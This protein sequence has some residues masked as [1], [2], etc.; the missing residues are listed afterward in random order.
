MV[1]PTL[2]AEPPF[3]FAGRVIWLEA[4][5]LARR[6]GLDFDRVLR[7]MRRTATDALG[8]P[9]APPAPG[10]DNLLDGLRFHPSLDEALAYLP[11]E[12]ALSVFER[13]DSGALS[14]R[15]RLFDYLADPT[16]PAYT[17][18]ELADLLDALGRHLERNRDP[19]LRTGYPQTS[20]APSPWLE[21]HL[22]LLSPTKLPV[23]AF[24]PPVDPSAPAYPSAS[25]LPPHRV[26][27]LY[28]EGSLPTDGDGNLVYRHV[29]SRTARPPAWS[30]D[31]PWVVRSLAD[32]APVEVCPYGEAAFIHGLPPDVAAHL[33]EG[34]AGLFRVKRDIVE[35]CVRCLRA[36]AAGALWPAVLRILTDALLWPEAQRYLEVEDLYW[37]SGV[38]DFVVP[39]Y[40]MR[41]PDEVPGTLSALLSLVGHVEKELLVG[42]FDRTIAGIAEVLPETD[43][44]GLES[45]FQ[46]VGQPGQAALDAALDGFW[47]LEEREQ[48]FWE[49][50]RSRVDAALE[51]E[52]REEVV[53]RARVKRR[54][55]ARFE[56]QIRTFAEWQRAHLEATGS[57]PVLHLAQLTTQ[58]TVDQAIFRKTGT[59]WTLTYGGYTA[60]VKDGH[61][62]RLVAHLL[63]RPNREIHVLDLV[64][65]L[66]ADR[67]EPQESHESLGAEGLTKL[68]LRV[69]GDAEGELLLDARAKSEYEQRI[70]E[71]GEQLEEA[72]AFDDT[73]RVAIIEQERAFI[74]HELAAAYGLDGKPR[75][76]V[77]SAER[78][79]TR[80]RKLIKAA[81]QQI[82]VHHP[83]LAYHLQAVKTGIYC[84]YSP[85]P[86]DAIDW[87]T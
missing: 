79:R 84:S 11:P 62:I 2:T 13:T 29:W 34:R 78:A 38:G 74:A 52:F 77:T 58:A 61:G 51:G 10:R 28:E 24:G 37:R 47:P 48:A 69:A 56:P 25:P 83:S 85:D 65:V 49:E 4:E 20:F 64:A 60:H 36:R 41:P 15:C 42:T 80:V 33:E 43:P 7:I 71:L 9:L 12:D 18:G 59:H 16:T 40:T 1:D 17:F 39:P 50:Y 44:A 87:E 76:T 45:Y 8:R 5:G 55:V 53:I 6:H 35:A 86:T 75:R 31:G 70:T 57:L 3:D 67:R 26:R 30:E 19:L 72:M 21:W 54:L 68:G 46:A 32:P 66:D 22:V 63:Q 14:R 82:A 23:S 27:L 81:R 73:E